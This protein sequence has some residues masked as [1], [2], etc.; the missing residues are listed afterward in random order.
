MYDIHNTFFTE[1]KFHKPPLA[2]GATT[3]N[4]DDA[5]H[6]ADGVEGVNVART[7]ASPYRDKNIAMH[8][9]QTGDRATVLR[10]MGEIYS[11]D[12]LKEFVRSNLLNS[13][14]LFYFRRNLAASV[15]YQSFINFIFNAGSLIRYRL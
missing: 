15:C 14:D 8:F 10:R 1:K 11:K 3:A 6:G 9:W 7:D 5:A 2:N 12:V 13:D 4:G